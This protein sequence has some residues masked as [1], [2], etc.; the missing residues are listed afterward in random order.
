MKLRGIVLHKR[1]MVYWYLPKT[2]CTAL[3]TYF[4][5][6]LG[7]KIPF[8]N[9]DEMDIHGQD[10]GF[11]FTENVIEGY[12]NFAYVRN[13]FDRVIS[14]YSQKINTENVDRKVFPDENIFYSFMPF[15]E[16]VHAIINI[17]NKERHYIPQS[18]LLPKGIYHHKME[19]D[20]FLKMIK[21]LN[22]SKKLNLYDNET[23]DLVYNFYKNDFIRFGYYYHNQ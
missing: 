6:E 16:F 2:C 11:E 10:I 3:K 14:L 4:A 8:K 18:E 17:P 22:V 7:L 13:P 23:L 15:D 19:S 12:Y 9:G 5:N 20:L 1:K 21:P